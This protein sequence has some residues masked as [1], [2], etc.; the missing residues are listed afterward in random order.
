MY[1]LY[2]SLCVV[3]NILLS[4]DYIQKGSNDG[5]FILTLHQALHNSVS[6]TSTIV[7]LDS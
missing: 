7:P 4:S 3:V 6:R 5:P 1:Y 2:A